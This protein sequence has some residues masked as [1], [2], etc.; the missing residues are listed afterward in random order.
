MLELT[1]DRQDEPILQ[2][3]GEQAPH[4]GTLRLNHSIA[5]QNGN[6]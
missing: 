3:F 4:A 6:Q 2:I 1:A 5:P